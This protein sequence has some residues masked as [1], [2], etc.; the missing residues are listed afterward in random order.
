MI[1]SVPD[2]IAA[3]QPHDHTVLAG[4][5]E[6]GIVVP[7]LS[8]HDLAAQVRRIAGRPAEWVSR[9]RLDPEGRWY[10]QIHVD[11]RY[12]LWLISWLPGHSTGFHDHGGANGAFSVVWG[13]L[14]ECVV[15]RSGAAAKVRPVPHGVVRAFGPHYIHDVRNTAADSVA[16]SVH[17]YSPPLSAMTRYDLTPSGLVV[18]GAE[19]QENW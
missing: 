14:D 9:V 2:D 1:S 5:P 17:A 3:G 12:E 18:T 15:P 6:S 13:T 19:T 10:E 8:Q 7:L 4:S 16:I 11:D